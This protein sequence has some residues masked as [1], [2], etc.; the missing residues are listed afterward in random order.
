[1]SEE[2]YGLGNTRIGGGGTG[3]MYGGSLSRKTLATIC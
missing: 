1:M 2:V 3:E